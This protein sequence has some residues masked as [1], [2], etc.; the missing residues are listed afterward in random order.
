[1]IKKKTTF[2][3]EYLTT[4]EVGELLGLSSDHVRQ[5]IMSNYIVGEKKGTIWLVKKE[6][7]RGIKRRRWPREIQ[8][9]E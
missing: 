9:K 6:D 4:Q 1:M 5:L 7:L 3:R 8:L 2:S